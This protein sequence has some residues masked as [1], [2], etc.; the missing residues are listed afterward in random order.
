MNRRLALG[1][2]GE[3]GGIGS[4]HVAVLAHA[5]RQVGS[6][7]E[8]LDGGSVPPF[9]D[10]QSDI[11]IIVGHVACGAKITGADAVT[12]LAG[13]NGNQAALTETSKSRPSSAASLYS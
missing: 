10:A 2:P 6:R 9:I 4:S 1:R 11:D 8:A 7:G 3:A 5:L 12:I 13:R